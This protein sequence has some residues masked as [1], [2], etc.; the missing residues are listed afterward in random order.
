MGKGPKSH[1]LWGG[2]DCGLEKVEKPEEPL[3]KDKSECGSPN[4][5]A[6]SEYDIIS[7]LGSFEDYL[8]EVILPERRGVPPKQ[9]G[10]EVNVIPVRNGGQTP[11][12]Q[13]YVS[14]YPYLVVKTDANFIPDHNAF[15][16]DR[17]INFV[18]QFFLYHISA[19]KPLPGNSDECRMD[20]ERMKGGLPPMY[21]C[22]LADGSPCS[23]PTQPN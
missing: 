7:A 16:N 4:L 18:E 15:Y 13:R 10:K 23:A 22:Q 14:S 20:P 3:R 21:S 5:K 17:F 9:Y 11:P 6:T 1:R 12:G 19:R 8:D 2:I